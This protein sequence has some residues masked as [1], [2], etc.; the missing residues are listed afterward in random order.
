M[1]ESITDRIRCLSTEEPEREAF[2]FYDVNGERKSVTRRALYQT[3]TLLAKHFIHFGMRKGSWVGLCMNNSLNMLYVVF[4]VSFAGGIPFFLATN[5]KD[6]SDVIEQMN[7]M[8]GEYLMID[9]EVSDPN[10]NIL[11]TIWGTNKQSSECVPALKHV[12]CNGNRFTASN[13]RVHLSALLS[14]PAPENIQ[15]PTIF[16][17]DILLCF[18]TSGST[19]KPKAV[20]WSHYAILNWG[21]NCEAS[22]CFSNETIYFCER[23]FAWAGGF[24][25][26]Y[27]TVGCTHVFVDTRLSLSGKCL[28]QLCNIIENEKVEVAYIPRY[29]A[30][31]LRRNPQYASKFRNLSFIITGGERFA[32][33][34]LSL[35]DEFCRTLISWYG[36]TETG[37]SVRFFSSKSEEYEEGIIGVPVPGVEVK[38]V[39]EKDDV[40]PVGECGELCIR[41]TWRFISYKTMPE[42]YNKVVNAVGWFHTGDSLTTYFSHTFTKINTKHMVL[43]SNTFKQKGFTGKTNDLFKS[44]SHFSEEDQKYVNFILKY[45]YLLKTLN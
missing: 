38:I 33:A 43:I 31:D 23:P 42:T 35:K 4:G 1:Y 32:T 25:R 29:I 10:W 34:L 8:K 15:L 36:N 14:T 3:S 26:L 17:E 16:P 40:V 24:P 41:C 12:V 13:C 19:G 28:D 6:G 39:N 2:V 18:C 22:L 7:D 9:A 11:E 45:I 44:V 30:K 20:V 27:L 21:Q 5:L 37:G